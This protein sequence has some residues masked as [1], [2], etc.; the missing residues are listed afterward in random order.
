MQKLLE[1]RKLWEENKRQG[2]LMRAGELSLDAA[3][4]IS[5]MIIERVKMRAG[6][7]KDPDPQVYYQALLEVFSEWG[8]MCPH[9]EHLRG[10]SS[11]AVETVVTDGVGMI[12]SRWFSCSLCNAAVINGRGT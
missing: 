1:H 4:R 6:G 2:P 12:F 7:E 11:K 8:I 10:Y 9:P 3:T 5:R